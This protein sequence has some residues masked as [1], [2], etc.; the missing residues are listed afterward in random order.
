MFSNLEDAVR[1]GKGNTGKC[2][3]YKAITVRFTM[4]NISIKQLSGVVQKKFLELC[5]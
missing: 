1:T 3:H 5:L 4:K 2:C